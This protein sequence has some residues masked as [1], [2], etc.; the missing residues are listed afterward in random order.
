[1]SPAIDTR[2][3]AL[4]E[5]LLGRY[6]LERELGRGGMGTVYLARDVAL[7]RPV[8]IKV[9]HPELAA[10]SEARA[11]FLRE[12]R[13][14]ARLAHP[15][16][17]PIF[18]VEE[19][20]DAVFFVMAVVDGETLGQRIRRRGPMHADDAGRMLRE[21][22]WALGYA[23]SHGVIHRDLTLENILVEHTTGRAVLADFGIAPHHPASADADTDAATDVTFSRRDGACPSR[24]PETADAR[25]APA[26][27]LRR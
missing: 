26:R 1:M 7:D 16:I 13:T 6:S 18:A 4:Q 8:A 24:L 11:L 22:A 14:A 19:H 15:H 12:A 2:L 5:L 23:H 20:A 27:P 9:L 10:Q 21:T 17:I 25:A 3:C